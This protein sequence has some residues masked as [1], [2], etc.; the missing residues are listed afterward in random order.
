MFCFSSFLITRH[1]DL[2]F[3]L[4]P[5]NVS[6]HENLVSRIKFYAYVY[7]IPDAGF[8]S[9]CLAHSQTYCLLCPAQSMELACL[10]DTCCGCSVI[11]GVAEARITCDCLQLQDDCND[12]DDQK[13]DMGNCVRSDSVFCFQMLLSPLLRPA[14]CL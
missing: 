6:N 2:H 12:V 7:E 13:L 10:L 9:L 3:T 8:I 1:Y 14:K 4:R 11:C 5:E